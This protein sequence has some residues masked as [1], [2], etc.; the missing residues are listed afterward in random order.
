MIICASQANRTDGPYQPRTVK[1]AVWD[2]ISS[3][4]PHQSL[5]IDGVCYA[6]GGDIPGKPPQI[7]LVQVVPKG[8]NTS[9][10][11]KGTR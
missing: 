6:K 8:W 1:L 9:Q 11:A 2:A 4:R 5:R 3:F 10:S 7:N